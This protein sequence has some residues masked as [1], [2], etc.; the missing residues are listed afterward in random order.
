MTRR[1]AAARTRPSVFAY[2]RDHPINSLA[3]SLLLAFMGYYALRFLHWAIAD[4]VTRADSVAGCRAIADGACWAVIRERGRL[5]LFGLYPFEEQWRPLLAC[6]I[7]LVAA[8]ASCLRRL[9]HARL[10]ISIWLAAFLAF[11]VLMGGGIFGLSAVPK[12]NWGGLALTFYIFAS[13]LIMGFPL[14]IAFTLIRWSGPRWA[15]LPVGLVV[16]LVRAIPL[17]V[18]LFFVALVLPSLIPGW[19]AADKLSR[20]VAGFALFFACYQAEILRGAFQGLDRG[21]VEAA[22]ALGLSYWNIQRFVVLPQILRTSLPQTVNQ[23]VTA[24]KDTSYVAIVGFFDMTASASAALGSREWAT[25][26]VEV[27]LVVGAVYLAFGYALAR[28]GAHLERTADPG[29]VRDTPA[30]GGRR[31]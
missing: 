30:G 5:I 16:D 6:A 9:Q 7:L 23:I 1:P 28:Y 15:A 27:Y 11:T 17:T 13:M 8:I 29:M 19:L 25:A 12:G 24:F 26:Y 18:I 2:V 31:S 21:Q 10:I 3:S 14:A 4:S 20:V 22:K